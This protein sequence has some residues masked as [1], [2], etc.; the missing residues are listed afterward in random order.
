MH[1]VS[2]YAESASGSKTFPCQELKTPGIS[3]G[4][5]SSYGRDG[6]QKKKV[7]TMVC[8]RFS[9]DSNVGFSRNAGISCFFVDELGKQSVQMATHRRISR[10]GV[11]RGLE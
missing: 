1:N 11:W 9:K 5:L 3:D 2:A 7:K 10:F 8:P 4:P 6:E